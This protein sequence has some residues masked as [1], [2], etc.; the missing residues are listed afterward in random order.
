MLRRPCDTRPVTDQTRRLRDAGAEM[1]GM[2][3]ALEAGEP[4]PLSAAY[5]TEPEADWG[6]R[7]ILAHVSEM[8]QYW[9]VQLGTVLAGDPATAVPFGRTASDPSRLGRIAADRLQPVGV[10]LD[11]ISTGLT[12]AGEFLDGL[13]AADL[14]RRGMHSIRGETTVDG[15]AE[16]F[17]V[18]HLGEHVV[19][20]RAIL[21]R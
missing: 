17:L 9:P 16:R 4:W 2:R 11:G 19:Q 20:L 13:S 8:L 15:A 21:E 5:G 14:A 12:T 6:P 18:A 1:L 7:E 10:L 3:G